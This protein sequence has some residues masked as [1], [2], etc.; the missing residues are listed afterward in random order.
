M[1]LPSVVKYTVSL[2]GIVSVFAFLHATYNHDMWI[3]QL[4]KPWPVVALILLIAESVLA[5]P[6]RTNISILAALVF[7]LL[8]MNISF[9]Y[10]EIS[11]CPVVNLSEKAFSG[12]RSKL[13]RDTQGLDCDY[14]ITIK[15]QFT[16]FYQI[17]QHNCIYYCA[18]VGNDEF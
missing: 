1:Q 10:S 17:C 3:R 11:H 13:F 14:F 9:I 15:I 4:T 8:G 18:N 5:V 7:C 16:Y 12:L 6:H 2:I